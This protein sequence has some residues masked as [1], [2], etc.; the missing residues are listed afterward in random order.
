MSSVGRRSL[1]L[2]ARRFL[3]SPAATKAVAPTPAAR[4]LLQPA[5]RPFSVL[6]NAPWSS[7]EKA[8]LALRSAEAQRS[9]AAAQQIAAP[10]AEAVSQN[11]LQAVADQ[12]AIS[13]EAQGAIDKM[14]TDNM[15][16][17]IGITFTFMHYQTVFI[18]VMR[19]LFQSFRPLLIL[20]VF[21]QILKAVFFIAGAP[22]WFSFYSIWLFEVGYGLAQCA[23]SFIFISF[24][25]NNLSFARTRGSLGYFLRAQREKLARASK[26]LNL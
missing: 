12:A 3:S 6:G 11:S 14:R 10:V 17:E 18:G 22:I 25:Y 9:A 7:A 13:A 2:M 8:S 19:C 26:A 1:G 16:F 21:G 24:F 4:Q 23:I 20:F 5:L 15:V